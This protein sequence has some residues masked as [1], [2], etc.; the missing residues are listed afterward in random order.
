VVP[1][2][3]AAKDTVG[4]VKFEENILLVV[5]SCFPL[6]LLLPH[7]IFRMTTATV[8][9]GMCCISFSQLAVAA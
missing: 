4:V 8:V 7:L 9:G 1:R 5:V 3:D 6:G 2:F